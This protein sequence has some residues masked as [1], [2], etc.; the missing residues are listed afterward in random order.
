MFTNLL[1]QSIPKTQCARYVVKVTLVIICVFF[2]VS[3]ITHSKFSQENI[4][5]NIERIVHIV[6][7]NKTFKNNF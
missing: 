3:K 4:L 7:T 6:S 5:S 2:V 1:K